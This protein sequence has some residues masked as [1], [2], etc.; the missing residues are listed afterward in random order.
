MRLSGLKTN[1]SA[2][3]SFLVAALL[4]LFS[5]SVTAQ[6]YS[7][8]EY[9]EG[10]GNLN[11]TSIVQDHT[12]YLWVGTQNGIYRYD[13][14][15]FRR[16][17]SEAGLPERSIMSLYVGQD[18]T[19]WVATTEGIYFRKQDGGFAEVKMLG[20]QG[21]ASQRTG[22][23]F[24]A[25]GPDRVVAATRTG[26]VDLHRV[27]TDVWAGT[28]LKLLGKVTWGVVF[29]REGTLWYGCDNDLCRMT[30]GQTERVSQSMGIPADTWQGMVQTRDGHVWLRGA[31]HVGEVD[32]RT[33]TYI[34]RDLPGPAYAE[35]Y[36]NIVQDQQGRVLVYAG[37]ELGVWEGQKWRV[38]TQRNGLPPFEMEGIFVDREGSVWLGVSGHGLRRWSAEDAWESYT[39]SS[40][41]NDNLVWDELRDKQGRLWIATEQGLNWIPADGSEPRAWHAPGIEFKRAGGLAVTPDGAIWAGSSSGIVVRIDPKTLGARQWK[42]PD[43]Y[44]MLVDGSGNVWAGTRE[45]LFEI[46][47]AKWTSG[48]HRIDAPVFGKPVQLFSEL[49]LDSTGHVWTVCPQGIFKLNE[50]GWTQIDL[51]HSD[52]HPDLI[53]FDKKGFLWTAG[54]SQKL[55]RMRLEGN[56]VVQWESYQRPEILSEQVVALM[57]DSRGWLWVGQDAGVSVFDGSEWRSFAREDGLV[58]NDVD[59]NAIRE[60]NDGSILIGTSGG[61]AHLINPST[62]A[63]HTEVPPVFSEVSYGGTSLTNGGSALWDNL[64]LDISMAVLS[65][66]SGHEANVRYRMKGA[67]D[68]G[69]DEARE[70]SIRYDHL[71]P[72]HYQFEVTTVD[73]A[74]RAASKPVTFQFTIRPRWWQRTSL[75][76]AVV[77]VT[78]IVCVLVWRWR[79]GQLIRQRRHLESAVRS[80]T[81]ELEREKNILV[82]MREQ[83]RHFAEHDG[84]S[85]L[86]N[87]RVIVERLRGEVDRSRRDGTPLS[88]ILADVDFFKR[89][90]DTYGHPV[91][92]R[93]LKE[94]STLF[95]SMVRSY[96]WV[97][98]YG[99]EEFLLVL[100]GTNLEQ[101][102]VRAEQ[103]RRAIESMVIMEGADRIEVTISLG[104]AA[105][106][107]SH[108]DTMVQTADSSLYEAKNNGRNRVVAT[109]IENPKAL[110]S[111]IAG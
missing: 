100:P 61:L 14:S 111:K 35:P 20:P 52:A 71:G 68:T 24:T 39:M 105:G 63:I 47:H 43:V 60:D 11:V 75:R 58:W 28:P 108:Y 89:I 88:I 27:G 77:F 17:G 54:P 102:R 15:Q 49:S 16:F 13:G 106:Y 22:S 90:N 83:M 81:E 82:G 33:H 21:E 36:P 23:V 86:W 72:G 4:F 12:G 3:A 95:Q 41:L 64:P 37:L 110:K 8:Q 26:A 55:M 42:M 85:G 5:A 79:V 73:H 10:L 6:R 53:A 109:E 93:V 74:G 101:A 46:E 44:R 9:T 103:M 91:G 69:W 65:F 66:K 78:L 2:T 87:H 51:G 29:D 59:S 50:D 38:L 56:R 7:F 25:A 99:G 97:G 76:I 32:T 62:L 57:V 104:V 98:R 92:D 34:G 67:V 18:G 80:R 96:D 70:F 48:P 30:Q 94:V 45:G 40:G 19:L 1:W 84:L 107:P 31:R